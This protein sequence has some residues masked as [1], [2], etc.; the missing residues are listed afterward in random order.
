M[1]I[2]SAKAAGHLCKNCNGIGYRGRVGVYEV[3][4]ITDELA[5][6]INQRAPT[7]IDQGNRRSARHEDPA[8][9]QSPDG[10]RRSHNSR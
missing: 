9:L 7:G 2:E 10:S 4:Q 6:L 3:M 5:T 8:G 1:E